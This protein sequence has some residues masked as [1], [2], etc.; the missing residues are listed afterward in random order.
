MVANKTITIKSPAF[1]QNGS[2]PVKHTCIGQNISPEL[3]LGD[4]PAETRSFAL[5]VDD[6]DAQGGEFVHWVMWN[7]PLK[8]KI[9]EN[10]SPGAQGKNGKG[11]NN[12]T[13]PCPPTGTHHY[14]FRLYALSVKLDLPVNTS[15][16]AL[17]RAMEGH[18]V[19]SGELIGHFKKI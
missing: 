3:I 14:Y 6:P 13:G 4:F 15:K 16:N 7:I 19:A 9:A 11:E 10:T 8:D 18:I 1:T 17:L 2:I 12:Y 5:I